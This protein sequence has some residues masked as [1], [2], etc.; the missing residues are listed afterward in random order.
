[1]LEVIIT[2]WATFADRIF[3]LKAL[4]KALIRV[5]SES[6]QQASELSDEIMSAATN[7]VHIVDS[8]GVIRPG[9]TERTLQDLQTMVDMLDETARDIMDEAIAVD[10]ESTDD[11]DG[12]AE[13]DDAEGR[14]CDGSK[15]GLEEADRDQHSGTE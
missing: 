13:R 11:G 1:M 10:Q 7:L 8:Y 2:L 5:P 15:D 9:V 4:A 6:I 3:S 12:D 14:M